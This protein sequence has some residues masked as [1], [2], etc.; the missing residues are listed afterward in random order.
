MD[1][2]EQRIRERAYRIW[3]DDGRPQGRADIHWDMASELVAIEDNQHLV[4]KPIERETGPTGEPIEPTIAV[5][6]A[7]EFPAMT[8]QGDEFSVPRRRSA[9]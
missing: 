1:N 2:R 5:E 3:L 8:D 7:G 9:G 4:R 6:N